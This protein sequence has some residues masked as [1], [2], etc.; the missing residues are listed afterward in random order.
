VSRTILV[1]AG[2]WLSVPP[3]GYGGIEN[4][5]ATL[6]PELRGLGVRV[7]LCAT[8]DSTLE[9][10]RLVPSFD[11]GQ[12]GQIAEPYNRTMGI[13]H[14]HM[15]T[16]VD[17]LRSEEEP[18]NLVHDH[19][20]VVGPAVL[21]AMG[22]A[23]PPVLQT[24][25]WDLRKHPDF[26]G[27]FDGRGRVRFCGVSDRQVELAPS[28]LCEQTLGAIPLAVDVARFPFRE[29]KDGP[30][31]VL[32]RMAAIKGPDVAARACRTAGHPLDL[33]GP[34]AGVDD[35]AA[36][37]AA[38]AD[39]GDPVHGHDD[40][41]YFE[42]AVRPHLGRDVRW[43]GSVEGERKLELLS[44]ARALVTPIRWEEPGATAV[45][46]A[47]ACG[48]PVIGMRRGAL[49]ALVDH[50]VTGFLADHEDELPGYLA[51]V[52]EIEPAACRAAAESR[53]TSRAFAEAYLKR[54]EAVIA[55]APWPAPP[56]SRGGHGPPAPAAAPAPR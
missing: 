42:A 48:T 22:R 37:N 13:A 54:Y 46:E 41:T 30:F 26:Y 14:A 25:H 8:A 1:N 29:V 36:L 53:F 51:R 44:R 24:L 18:I 31:L 32:G 39:L 19:L 52:D 3:R 21:G 34:V 5:L 56:G 40:A 15:G 43:I 49:P 17:F 2:P 6:I 55:G 28:R 35:P 27:S 20:E 9:V 50:G 10:D 38:L 11:R 4:V 47:L 33:A 16:L 23:A 7:V 12:F 45:V